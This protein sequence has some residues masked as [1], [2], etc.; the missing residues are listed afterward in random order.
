MHCSYK[1]ELELSG[2]IYR[3]ILNVSITEYIMTLPTPTPT[4]TDK[5]PR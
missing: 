2:Q 1:E 4:P 3:L 5:V